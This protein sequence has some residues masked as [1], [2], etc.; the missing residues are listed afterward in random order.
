MW[1]KIR[2]RLLEFRLP[3]LAHLLLNHH[4]L[5]QEL[6]FSPQTLYILKK[7]PSRRRSSVTNCL[8]SSMS[9]FS[10]KILLY[11]FIYPS[12]FQLNP[13]VQL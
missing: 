11:F 6:G 9:N 3:D 4:F 10:S 7:F 12:L 5:S 13:M 8:N 1:V 2:K